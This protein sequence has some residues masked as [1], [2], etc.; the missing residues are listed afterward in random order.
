MRVSFPTSELCTECSEAIEDAIS[1]T[2]VDVSL[3]GSSVSG[4]SRGSSRGSGRLGNS[5]GSRSSVVG[6][7]ATPRRR[8]KRESIFDYIGEEGDSPSSSP[9]GSTGDQ[10]QKRA[11]TIIEE[12]DEEEDE[13]DQDDDD[14]EKK[15][16]LDHETHA[17]PSVEGFAVLEMLRGVRVHDH[18]PSFH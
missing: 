16:L 8:T 12:D 3:M 6:G 15:N 5:S 17:G 14:D 7:G 2:G 9:T 18:D 1:G 4:G 10:E 13:E 11:S